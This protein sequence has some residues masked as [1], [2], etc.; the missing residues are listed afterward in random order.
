MACE[1]NNVI[2]LEWFKNSGYKFKYNKNAL[3]GA[4]LNGHI[5][6][7]KWF[8]NNYRLKYDK[9]LIKEYFC[10]DVLKFWSKNINVK[11]IIKWSK[12]KYVKTLKFKTKNNYIKGYS[13][14]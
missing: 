8:K 11:K 6:S 10:L 14:N 2:I 1:K 5:K 9:E 7:L 12:Y 4:S 3:Y 13:K